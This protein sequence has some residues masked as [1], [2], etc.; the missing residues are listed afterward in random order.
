MK[1]SIQENGKEEKVI[2]EDKEGK[3]YARL[4]KD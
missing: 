4:F 1:I 3:T 2:F